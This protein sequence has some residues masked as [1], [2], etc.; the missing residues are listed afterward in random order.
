MIRKSL[1]LCSLIGAGDKNYVGNT[2]LDKIDFE[3]LIPP[4]DICDYER[5]YNDRFKEQDIDSSIRKDVLLILKDLDYLPCSIDEIFSD[6]I[7]GV[8]PMM[9]ENTI[10]DFLKYD[11]K[12]KYD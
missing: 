7:V 12:I 1:S 5:W 11:S 2:D 6:G 10:K 3:K 8:Q 4:E 9:T